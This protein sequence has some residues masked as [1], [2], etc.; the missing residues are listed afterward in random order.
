M[1]GSARH[2][3]IS[4]IMRAC[5]LAPAADRSAVLRREAGNDSSII[6]EVESLLEF[7][8]SNQE[9]VFSDE[10]IQQ[11]RNAVQRLIDDTPSADETCGLP[12]TIA[13]YRVIRKLGAGGM[14]VVYEAE[15]ENPRRRVALKVIRAHQIS[16]QLVKRFQREAFVLGRLQHPGIAHVYES[17]FANIGTER[18]PY[19]AMELIE[20]RPLDVYAEQFQLSMRERLELVAFAADAIHHAHQ[21][22]II[23]RDLKPGNILVVDHSSESGDS[24]VIDEGTSG[25]RSARSAA[26]RPKIV[27]FGVARATDSDVPLA[28]LQTHAGH[29][30]GTMNYMS[31]EQISGDVE[32]L[33]RR[34]DVYALGV[35]LHE[36]L[37]GK[38]P[39][40]VSRRALP[41]AARM[42]RDEEPTRLGSINTVYRGDVETIVEKAL[43]KDP[44]RRYLTAAEMA[45]DIRRYLEDRPIEARRAGV[46]Y[47][48]GK[49]AR[50][51]RILVGGVA[52]TV[53]ALIIGLI[54]TTWLALRESVAHRDADRAL[55]RTGL[56]VAEAALRDGDVVTA[57]QHLH[58]A[59]EAL[60]GWEW[61]HYMARLD[62]SSASAPFSEHLKVMPGP[63]LRGLAHCWF[64][65]GDRML[66]AAIFCINDQ[67]LEVGTWEGSRL[68]HERSWF[69]PKGRTS[70]PVGDG[71][72]VVVW[73]ESEC[74]LHDAVNGSVVAAATRLPFDARGRLDI[75]TTVPGALIEGDRG[76]ALLGPLGDAALI[77]F[78]SDARYACVAAKVNDV[79]VYSLKDARPPMKLERHREGIGSSVFTPDGQY[80]ITA[81]N[82]RR[83]MCFDLDNGGRRVWERSDAHQDAILA[84]A[85]SPD[86]TL[87]AT[88]GQDRV[89]RVWDARTGAPLGRLVGHRDPILAVAFSSDGR[90]I[91][92]FSSGMVKTWGV[93]AARDL[94]VMHGHD[95]YVYSLAISPDGAL[96]ASYGDRLRVWDAR[97]GLGV[98]EGAPREGVQSGKVSFSADGRTLLVSSVV[99]R[100]RGGNRENQLLNMRTGV[101]TT[102]SGSFEPESALAFVGSG[103]F[104][105]AETP[106]TGFQLLA[107]TTF[108]PIVSLGDVRSV[109]VGHSG[110]R[111]ACIA[112]GN[113]QVRDIETKEVIYSV[114]EHNASQLFLMRDESVVVV[115]LAGG[116][117]DLYDVESGARLGTL[118]GHAARVTCFAELPGHDRLVT[119]SDDRTIRLW[120]IDRLRE[121]CVL[122][123]HTDRI[124]DLAVMPGEGAFFSSCGDYTIRRWDTRPVRDLLDARQKYERIAEKLSPKISGMLSAADGDPSRVVEELEADAS[125][126]EREREVGQELVWQVQT[127]KKGEADP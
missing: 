67:R 27:D 44:D 109:S 102:P 54:S 103:R 72:S 77:A 19:L 78:S 70:A 42:I 68:R 33:D 96:L 107:P 69:I 108:E 124:W 116:A 28:T 93:E 115:G 24:S 35:I 106:G 47:R 113:V 92:S 60:R 37:A 22:G 127:A 89:L 104:V 59:P 48:A 112:G 50:R 39:L 87:L 31:P 118:A 65:H 97:T 110:R 76:E 63:A 7:D 5:L 49:F 55:Y 111:L 46:W 85:V 98:F 99:P 9:D 64:S 52:T 12:A 101:L 23:H 34:C 18:L 66:H 17:G 41:E 1:S 38:P 30:L 10:A 13:S 80:L 122:R 86:G 3:R 8:R 15:Q 43:E 100:Q 120:D 91:A 40:D 123:G 81:G 126:S 32:K 6:R 26:G 53:L 21:K 25:R 58:A 75:L 121:V 79:I 83:L 94:N 117:I 56:A 4:E 125:L 119:G 71:Q 36:L 90:R 105:L 29:L 20:G 45:A 62:Q 74:Q 88:G 84:A 11:G 61:D 14:G 2:E 114:Q 51:N 16:D 57:S 82:D 73:N 95:W